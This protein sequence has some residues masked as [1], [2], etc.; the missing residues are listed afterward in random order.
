MWCLDQIFHSF[1]QLDVLFKMIQFIGDES[2]VG[3]D[4]VQV[5]WSQN[6]LM[7]SCPENLNQSNPFLKL[8]AFLFNSMDEVKQFLN[9]KIIGIKLIAG[10]R[11]FAIF[12]RLV[13][14]EQYHFRDNVYELV[15]G[16]ICS[17]AAQTYSVRELFSSFALCGSVFSF[18]I[19][20][21]VH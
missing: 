15:L 2:I 13:G 9:H 7:H 18:L 8:R 4:H 14:N 10:C 3:D 11:S 12:S 1:H 20:L 6:L 17:V 19:P 5:Y 16:C 21:N